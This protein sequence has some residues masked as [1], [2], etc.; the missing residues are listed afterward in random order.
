MRQVLPYLIEHFQAHFPE[1]LNLIEEI[2]LPMF[3]REREQQVLNHLITTSR[4][5][6]AKMRTPIRRPTDR[7]GNKMGVAF[8]IGTHFQHKRYGYEGVVVSWD[9][10]CGAEERWIEQ[11]GVDELPRGREQPFYRVVSVVSSL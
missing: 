11:M 1:D 7:H 9:D 8:T 3:E 4:V 5:A 6:D 10:R 2:V